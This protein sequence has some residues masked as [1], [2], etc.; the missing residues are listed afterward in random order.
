MISMNHAKPMI[1]VAAAAIKNQ[2]GEILLAKRP[3]HKHKGDLWEFPGGKIEAGET[4]QEALIRELQE[5]L[6]I[7]PRTF[8]PLITLQHHY[9]EKSIELVVFLV[10]AFDG[11]LLANEGQ[12]LAWVRPEN[13]NHYAMPEADVPIVNA[14]RLPRFI[15][16][17]PFMR[18]ELSFYQSCI[19]LLAMGD[20]FLQLRDPTISDEQYS[21]IA[22]TLLQQT[23]FR[24]RVT[25]NRDAALVNSLEASAIHLNSAQLINRATL[26]ADLRAR[27]AWISASV[28][29]QEE[30]AHAERLGV[31]YVVLSPV[32]AT[33]T[34]PTAT[35]L[36]WPRFSQWV[37]TCAIPVYAMGGLSGDDYLC[38]VQHGAQ[39]VA[40]IRGF[41]K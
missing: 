33:A 25:L 17:T 39:G 32:Q 15:A 34:H 41:W 13:M 19:S 22:R 37:A 12:P 4:D 31:D 11:Q 28:H 36:G 23:P 16:I 40:G 8:Q 20:V 38:A 26:T 5:E 29:N 30:L 10:T 14:L 21:T 3:P 7:T 27:F 2:H 35:P 1:R 24:E 6:N 9:P 18:D